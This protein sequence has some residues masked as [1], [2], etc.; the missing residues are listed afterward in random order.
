MPSPSRF[1]I[2]LLFSAVLTL[3]STGISYAQEPDDGPAAFNMTAEQNINNPIVPQKVSNSVIRHMD[4]LA[5]TFAKHEFEVKKIRRGEVLKV[6]IPTD[7]L[8]APNDTKLL[9]SAVKLLNA[10]EA[11]VTR[12]ELYKL[13]IMAH[14]DNTGDEVYSDNLSEV[15]ANA[16]DEYFEDLIKGKSANIIPYGMGF[17]EPVVNNNSISNRQRNRRIEIYIIPESQII[18]M[19]KKGKLT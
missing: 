12:P 18:D 15:R 19:A 1:I 17:D 7:V 6:I 9:P 14:T 10:F 11:L 2:R 8:F 5:K 4:G 16:V 3:V 13:V